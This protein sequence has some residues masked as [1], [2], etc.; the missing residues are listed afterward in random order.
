M[1]TEKKM[2]WFFDNIC[3]ND[4]NENQ[5]A[6]YPLQKATEERVKLFPEY[7]D[8]IRMFYGRWVEML[9][10]AIEG[11]VSILKSFI[12]N[13]KY[14]VVALTNWSAETFPIALDRF[15]FL[16]WFDGILVSGEEKT[17]KPFPEIY[18]LTLD[19]FNIK[20]E[21]SIFIDDN[22]RNIKAANQLG[23]NGIHFESPEVLK[24]QL[25][26]YSIHI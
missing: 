7:E 4:W 24:D 6:G 22:L 12:D 8:L 16:H 17:R 25:K 10:E 18:Q 20:P 23:I 3:T 1:E 13:P 5:D 19:R 14:K 9:G 11:T 15:E 26:T 2:K 21:H